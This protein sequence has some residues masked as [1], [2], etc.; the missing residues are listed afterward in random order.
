MRG[1]EKLPHG[2][3]VNIIVVSDHGQG[4]YLEDQPVFTL[5][6]HVN[7]QD[8][9]SIDG[10]SYLFLYFNKDDPDRARDIVVTVNRHWNHGTAYVPADAPAQWHI[11][12]NPRFPD[13]ILMPDPG[14]AILSNAQLKHKINPGD[15]G[16]VPEMPEMHGFFVASGPNI[17]P[18]MSLGPINNVDIYP[19]MTSILGLKAPEKL[20]G[21]SS[22]LSGILNPDG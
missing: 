9:V 21:D 20:D 7:L 15:H 22:K 10:G 16:W 18:G 4:T 19:L 8:I 6:E 5:D 17:K 1:L 11:D 14:F 13:V 12:N 2:K 3:Q